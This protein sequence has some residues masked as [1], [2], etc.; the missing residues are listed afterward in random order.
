MELEDPKDLQA[1]SRKFLNLT[2]ERKKM[3]KKTLRKRIS[4]VAVS[5]LGAT[6]LS[7]VSIAPANANIYQATNSVATDNVLG[8]AVGSNTAASSVFGAVTDAGVAAFR[9]QGL[10]FKDTSSAT[11]QTATMLPTG[12]L[13]F[14][15]LTAAT[16]VSFIASGGT[17]TGALNTAADTNGTTNTIGTFN[18]SLTHAYFGNAATTVAVRWTPN[19]AGTYTISHYETD[20][21]TPISSSF[22]TSGTLRG[23][24]TVTVVATS[25]GGTYS[26]ADSTCTI[27]SGP[28]A[29]P[30]TADS[31]A[32]K[33]NGETW[34]INYTLKDAYGVALPAGV[35]SATATN[36]ALLS[37]GSAG[38]TAAV[39]TA[40]QVVTAT[41]S[42]G[43]LRIAQPVANAPVTT[44]VVISYNGVAVCTKAL[45]IRGQVEK[46]T[47][48]PLGTQD[49]STAT[50]DGNALLLGDT[51]GRVAM[52]TVLATDSAGNQVATPSSLGTF[53]AVDSTL[54]TTVTGIGF[55][56]N[57]LA[58]ATSSTDIYRYST[59]GWSCGPV[60][61]SSK[62]QIKYLNLGS[63]KIIT[64]DAF[65][66]Q[67][68]D[69]PYSFTVSLDKGTYTQG[70]IATMTVKF[71]D[72]KGNPANS[73][74]AT[75]GPNTIIMPWMT[76]VSA[77]GSATTLANLQGEVK[78]TMTVGTTSGMTAGTYTGVVD[79]GALTAAL[80]AV[81]AT[82]TYKLVTGGDTTSNA[83]VLKSI[84]ALIASINKQI[85][86]LQKLILRR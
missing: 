64:S 37:L 47:V 7:V 67:C 58:T 9:P 86:A 46:L 50:T 29:T 15:T 80:T 78:Y 82:P 32:T 40:P 14:Y 41:T 85:Q 75:G 22:P 10:L 31:T 69:N 68:A 52:F 20:N 49:L 19:A 65:T 72:S 84:V 45:T 76:F 12:A 62:V 73:T 83:D 56:A 28:L 27:G 26:A 21:T 16:A 6:L 53:S 74:V 44:S 48:T 34:F 57:D 25:G 39:G 5:A 38:A 66:A 42:S 33:K 24:I 61:G 71:L 60:A 2:N 13:V 59:G 35:I 51:S 63:G 36:S 30:N 18:S 70:D 55:P 17:F 1:R 79:F 11:A 3:S 43:S 23:A 81:K 54:T 4:L 77:T 8:V